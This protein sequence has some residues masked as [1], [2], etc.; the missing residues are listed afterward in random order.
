MTCMAGLALMVACGEKKGD[1]NAEQQSTEQNAEEQ[2]TENT[3]E[4]EAAEAQ[5]DAKAQLNIVIDPQ[6]AEANKAIYAKGDFLPF[7]G[8]FFLDDFSAEKVGEFP[9]KWTQT[10]GSAE[11]AEFE[12]RKVMKLENNDAAVAPKVVGESKNY[13]PQAFTLE[14]EYYCNGDE[15]YNANF[16]LWFDTD[17]GESELA[18][19]TEE[20]ISWSIYKKNDEGMEGNYSK[21]AEVEKK[22]SWNHFA[23][24][25]V[26][27][28]MKIYVNGQRIASLPDV[29]QPKCLNIKGEGWE[30]HRDLLTNVRLTTKAPEK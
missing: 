17:A 27:G 16:H 2:N 3:T 19:R 13:L 10:N 6:A 11:V 29:K 15:D 9:S 25:F 8:V 30:D 18:L 4:G 14:F 7:P 26:D 24:S 28:T 21:L 5:G 1:A 22:N 23:L 20:N 12:G